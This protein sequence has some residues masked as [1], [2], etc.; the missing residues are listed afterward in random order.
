MMKSNCDPF[1]PL[2]EDHSAVDENLS[3]AA[4]SKRK[5]EN[6]TKVQSKEFKDDDKGRA[7]PI[8]KNLNEMKLI[9]Y[10]KPDKA[11]AMKWIVTMIKILSSLNM[12]P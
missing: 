10:T 6:F 7:F 4:R 12:H 2:V 11:N 9:H 5:I 3:Y 1:H 8:K